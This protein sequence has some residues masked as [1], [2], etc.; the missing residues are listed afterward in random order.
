M[1]YVCGIVSGG[2]YVVASNKHLIILS[3]L[4][5][6]GPIECILPCYLRQDIRILSWN[7]MG[8]NRK[9]KLPC[10]IDSVAFSFFSEYAW[11]RR[12]SECLQLAKLKNNEQFCVTKL[13]R[14]SQV[15]HVECLGFPGL[16]ERFF[17][18]WHLKLHVLYQRGKNYLRIIINGLLTRSVIPDLVCYYQL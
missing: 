12:I 11:T 3:C 5:T 1:L 2:E 14:S 18:Y 15:T 8:R 17:Y 9:W 4:S 10:Y 6:H 13:S 16:K 7:V